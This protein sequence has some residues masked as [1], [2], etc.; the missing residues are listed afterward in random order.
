[1]VLA[2]LPVLLLFAE[3]HHYLQWRVRALVPPLL[4][5]VMLAAPALGSICDPSYH[6]PP[7]ETFI[8][9]LLWAWCGYWV[10][11]RTNHRVTENTEKNTEG[12]KKI[13]GMKVPH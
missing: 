9:L 6:F 4:L 5:F 12:T 10:W 1:F 13:L 11:R 7:W 2:G 8:L 3:P